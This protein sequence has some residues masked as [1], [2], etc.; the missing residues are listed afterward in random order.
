[1]NKILPASKRQ[2]NDG[3]ITV[4]FAAFFQIIFISA[5]FSQVSVTVTGINPTCAGYTNG[6][7]EAT[8]SG[9]WPPYTYVWNTGH[10]GP[11]IFGVGAGTYTVTVTDIDLAI[12]IG[13][14]TLTTPP[15]LTAIAV[16]TGTVC[17][18]PGDVT[19]N[20]SGGTA[21]YT[22][23]WSNG[24][25]SQS[26]TGLAAG[27]YCVTVTDDNDCAAVSCI[28]VTSPLSVTVRTIDSQCAMLCDGSAM[29]EVF[30]G[31]APYTF[32][33]NTGQTSQIIFPL[34]PGTYTVTVTDANGCVVVGS[35]VVSEPPPIIIDLVITHPGCLNVNG[36]SITASASG[37]VPGYTFTWSTGQIGPM[38]SNLGPGTYTLV[39]TDFNNCSVDTSVVL[40]STGFDLTATA[41]DETCLGQNDGTASASATGGTAPYSFVWSNG[42]TGAVITGLSAG[43]YTVT[44]TDNAGCS[45]TATVV[46]NAG[47]SPNVSIT[48]NDVTICGGTNGSAEA[49][50]TGGVPPY[51]FIWNTGQTGPLI[52]GL[53]AGTYTVTATDAN[54]CTGAATVTINQPGNIQVSITSQSVSCFGGN[55][56]SAT[57][58]VSGGTAPYTYAWSNGGNSSTVGNLTAG[59]YSV[60]VSDNGGCSGSASVT[61]GQPASALICTVAVTDSISTPG[62][63]DGQATVTASGGTPGYT[64][65]W[66]NGQTGPTA[67]GLAAGTYTVTVTDSE[68]CTSTCS[69]E[70]ENPR[71]ILGKLGDFVWEDKN[72]NGIQDAGEPGIRAV[73]V[74]LTGTTTAGVAVNEMTFTAVNGMYMFNDLNPGTY[75]LTFDTPVN[76]MVTIQNAGSD[77]AKDSDINPANGMITNI[78]LMPGDT[79][80]T[81]D[82]GFYDK[83]VNLNSAGTIGYDEEFCGPG[84]DPALIVE[85]TPPTG[86]TGRIEYLWMKS[87][88]SNV[89]S[90]GSFQP[91]PGATGQTYNPP[92]IYE[93]TYYVRCTRREFCEDFLETNIVAKIV[94]DD[95]KA[96]INGPSVVCQGQ[97]YTFFATDEGP[98]ATYQWDF[99]DNATPRTSNSRVVNNVSW[100][101]FGQRTVR[102]TVNANNC[103][104]HNIL[105][106]V[107][108]T[109][110]GLC[111]N[112]MSL[113]S[114]IINKGEVLLEWSTISQAPNYTYLVRR[115][116]DG[117][118]FTSIAELNLAGT[119]DQ[120]NYYSFVDK[121]PKKGHS[122]YQI[123]RIETATGVRVFSNIEHIVLVK[124]AD[125][126]MIY[127]NPTVQNYVY[128][129]RMATFDTDGLIEIFDTKGN[130]MAVQNF[131]LAV[132]RQQVDI[133]NLLPGVY[134]LKVKYSKAETEVFKL[135][136]N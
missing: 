76:F 45:A 95:A 31:T 74:T 96:E 131:E 38:I 69:V 35:G 115:S 122:H 79:N 71:Y 81:F 88:T 87:T 105:K 56:G 51:S 132:T 6:V 125:M 36:G 5:S 80:L 49:T 65:V 67:I 104:A 58:V 86:G 1:M 54:G 62:G 106:I 40:I 10:T 16:H 101:N 75:K 22:F 134:I 26:Q 29:A 99:G 117:I 7:V 70:L 17:V 123:I 21:P 68:G 15:D 124:D 102:L 9:G 3:F 60:T 61:I 127:P 8:A 13:S 66:S 128:V 23:L 57:A 64:Y 30:G 48:K 107:I 90:T 59:V 114:T 98:G 118:N 32:L 100:T 103:V 78:L 112:S 12:A 18:N 27:L 14:V 109:D 4:F 50:A 126:V 77:D 2:G 111:G 110:P 53:S 92:V 20:V 91:I 44:A 97:S 73:K 82:A 39:V 72:M 119:P 89:F 121:S 28:T 42:S 135:I 113:N 133:S 130:L 33:W 84:H 41:T 24:S 46:V 120:M 136:K 34:G 37:G 93:T 25:T 129:E 85:L 52:T 94:D 55:D 47:S 43:T 108:V 19:V 83:C 63:N 11:A 116:A